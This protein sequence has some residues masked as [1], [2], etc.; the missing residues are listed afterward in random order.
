MPLTSAAHTLL[1]RLDVYLSA[2]VPPW[3]HH[4]ADQLHTFGSEDTAED[5]FRSGFG[6]DIPPN[7]LTE[8]EACLQHLSQWAQHAA[9]APDRKFDTLCSVVEFQADY[10]TGFTPSLRLSYIRTR[11]CACGLGI[12][13]QILYVLHCHAKQQHITLSCHVPLSQ[14]RAEL[15]KI[16][17]EFCQPVASSAWCLFPDKLDTA[18]FE[19]KDR[20]KVEHVGLAGVYVTVNKNPGVWPSAD[21]MNS[22]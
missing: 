6:S 4:N 13:K 3:Y 9:D 10:C 2:P 16:S 8:Y 5:H 17:E 22:Q 21:D 19:L 20:I 15:M 12:L 7:Y 18:K 11:P 1:R 14:T